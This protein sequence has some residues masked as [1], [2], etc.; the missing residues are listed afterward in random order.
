MAYTALAFPLVWGVLS[1]WITFTHQL[2]RTSI[3]LF[4]IGT[5]ATWLILSLY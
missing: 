3:L 5:A 4:I 2:A 1:V